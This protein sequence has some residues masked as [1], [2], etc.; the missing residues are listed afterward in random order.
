MRPR[1]L[2]PVQRPRGTNATLVVMAK[3]PVAGAVKTRLASSLGSVG[4]ARAAR[5]LLQRTLRVA[6]EGERLGWWR[7]VIAI[8]RP[9]AT[10]GSSVL[11][12]SGF[13]SVAQGNGDLGERLRRVFQRVD[14][15]GPIVVIGADSP[16]L[17]AAAI[18]R[19]FVAL[20]SADVVFG[21][22][23]DGGFWAIGASRASV[24]PR[25][26]EGIRWSTEHALDD[27]TKVVGSGLK[28]GLVDVL[29]DID[30]EADLRSASEDLRFSSKRLG[31]VFG[32][33]SA[34][35]PSGSKPIASIA[36]KLLDKSRSPLGHRS[37]RP[38]TI[39]KIAD[40][41]GSD[42]LSGQENARR[43]LFSKLFGRQRGSTSTEAG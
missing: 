7:C 23:E 6:K 8:D 31:S 16:A 21:P 42:R 33:G 26:F 19:V 1:K 35:R 34:A 38:G 25:R 40:R 28:V 10:I 27:T 13:D 4:A 36:S 29:R 32:T 20:G 2:E 12:G 43:S 3:A 22:A 5:T 11:G 17:S 39:D 24:L 37:N 41:M 15:G 9:A 30:N 18:R 14:T